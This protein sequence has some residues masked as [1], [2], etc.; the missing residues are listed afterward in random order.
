MAHA[1]CLTQNACES[2]N[3]VSNSNCS[4]FAYLHYPQKFYSFKIHRPPPHPPPT[5]N[6][7]DINFFYCKT[8]FLNVAVTLLG[9][10][11]IGT[12]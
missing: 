4:V 9:F 1:K 11:G 10:R 3:Y 7:H 2:I 12:P 5:K 8:I 6:T